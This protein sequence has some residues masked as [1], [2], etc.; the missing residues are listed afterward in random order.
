MKIVVLLGPPGCGKGTQADLIEKNYGL[1]KLSTGDILRD[2]AKQSTDIA[3][4]L[5]LVMESGGLVSDELIIK[6]IEKRLLEDD[7]INGVILDGFPR[8]L[9]QANYL[10]EMIG[11][12]SNFNN[13]K[14]TII[15]LCLDDNTIIKRI[16]GRFTCRKCLA[17]YHE[18]F[19]PTK[20]PDI[21][22]IC[23]SNDFFRRDDDSKE[24]AINRLKNYYKDTAPIVNY[25]EKR[26]DFI[27]FNADSDINKIYQKL[28]SYIKK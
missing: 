19:K 9:T 27:S 25:Y 5:K 10:D 6:V 17:G 26:K 12:N 2:I 22:D 16:T 24:V 23:G 21:C 13:A 1:K 7:C 14:I 11:N 4:Q 3:K 28:I 8:T 15:S 20:V 18:I